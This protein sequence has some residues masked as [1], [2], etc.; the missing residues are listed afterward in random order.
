SC[1]ITGAATAAVR[2]ST[3]AARN[4]EKRFFIMVL[5]L[6]KIRLVVLTAYYQLVRTVPSRVFCLTAFVMRDQSSFQT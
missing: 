6:N 5:P 2:A 3:A 1:A 4:A